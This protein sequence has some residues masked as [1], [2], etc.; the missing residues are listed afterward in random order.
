MKTHETKKRRQA[1][2]I[3][4]INSD[5]NIPSIKRL[6]KNGVKV[7]NENGDVELFPSESEEDEQL[8]TGINKDTK[9]IKKKSNRISKLENRSQSKQVE[10]E[11]D[12]PLEESEQEEMVDIV[13][14]LD[15]EDW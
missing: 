3:D 2:Q 7:R 4:N 1:A 14:E 9:G 10:P 6:S 12:I 15:I 11:A 13:K 8:L 5:Y